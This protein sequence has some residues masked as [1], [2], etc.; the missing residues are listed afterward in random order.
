MNKGYIKIA[1]A[2]LCVVG[3]MQNVA[4]ASETAVAT[5][6][7]NEE[8][9]QL[10]TNTEKVKQQLSAPP[11]KAKQQLNLRYKQQNC[12]APE[13][14]KQAED[15]MAK[16]LNVAKKHAKHTNDYKVY[17]AENGAILHFKSLKNASMGKLV[18]TIPNADSYADI[19]KM[20]WD[21]N[22]EK[23]LNDS[24]IEGKI[25]RMYNKNLAIIQQRYQG[26]IWTTYYNALANKVELSEDETAIVLV[27]S[28]MNDHN[29]SKGMNYVN[30]IVKSANSFKPDFNSEIDIKIGL[31]HKAY[32]NLM[33]IFIKK[34]ANGVKITQLTSIE[35]AYIPDSPSPCQA[36]R[37]MTASIM[38]N[39]TKIGNI[40]AN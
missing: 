22:A 32:I 3:Y 9:K 33:A 35:H 29:S 30:P 24:F 27:S 6:S 40:I 12:F 7:S 20:L 13:E 39:T 19:V 23:K 5:N 14:A 15:V 18:F 37:A 10:F 26:P 34:E 21:Q 16:A 1:L 4:S 31:L 25:S 36:L 8:V 28:N 11:K 17:Y 38:L 2:L